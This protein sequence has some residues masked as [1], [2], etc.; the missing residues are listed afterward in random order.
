MP[1]NYDIEEFF[2]K[3]AEKILT[4]GFIE[5]R[6][7]L[8]DNQKTIRDGLITRGRENSEQLILYEKDR[9]ANKEDLILLGQE[10]SG[11]NIAGGLTLE[12]ILARFDSAPTIQINNLTDNQIQILLQGDVITL[13]QNA[14]G[15][16]V[17]GSIVS[18][19]IDISMILSDP[20]GNNPLNV[21]QFMSF[22]E[23]ET[24]VDP[25]Q[26][27]EF[28]NTT[29]FE[30]LPGAQTRQERINDFFTEY[31][32]LKGDEPTFDLDGDGLVDDDFSSYDY[33][34]GHDI[35]TAQDNMDATIAEQDASITRIQ[36]DENDNNFNQSLEWL[37]DDLNRYLNDVDGTIVEPDESIAD[38]ENASSG[39]LQFSNLNQGI[40]VRN[41]NEEFIEGL[42][43]YKIEQNMNGVD[44][45]D[46]GN[47]IDSFITTG[48][49]ITLWVRFLDKVSEGTLF[50]FG[51]PTRTNNPMGFKLE[52]LV[53]PDDSARYVRLLV[54]DGSRYYDSHTGI[55]NNNKIDTSTLESLDDIDYEQWTKIPTDFSEWYFI[56]ANYNTSVNETDSELYVENPDFWLNHIANSDGSGEYTA[57]SDYGNRAKVEFISRS[58]LLRARGY[59]V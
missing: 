7:E 59:K 5:T 52:T 37:R 41:T 11:V 2:D 19:T 54:W 38:Y 3:L 14:D 40:I 22:L 23:T 17:E 56:C 33:S 8:F 30:L 36:S 12:Q 31:N 16:M 10:S 47:S 27:N 9:K 20:N 45:D 58:D 29:I 44:E 50:N 15:E 39:Y 55:Q 26:A 34:L 6:Q 25:E 46:D 32:I 48:F 24:Q 13:T 28:L 49:T 21:S 53:N 42:D 43:P 57:Y 18:D 51:N 35:S 4:S 1:Y